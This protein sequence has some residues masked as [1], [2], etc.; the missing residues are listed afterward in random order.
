MFIFFFVSFDALLFLTLD[1]LLI[2]LVIVFFFPSIPFDH[3]YMCI[4]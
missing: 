3:V 2:Y 4:N 1:F